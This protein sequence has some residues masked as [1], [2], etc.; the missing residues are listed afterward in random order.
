M[1]TSE[2]RPTRPPTS[3]SG[4]STSVI[5]PID[6][7][8]DG[9]GDGIPDAGDYFLLVLGADLSLHGNMLA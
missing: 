2:L 6:Q 8:G 9:F 1:A 3:S 4:R 7:N 5:L